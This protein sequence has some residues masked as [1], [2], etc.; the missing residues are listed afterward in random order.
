MTTSILGCLVGT[1]GAYDTHGR[2]FAYNPRDLR[3]VTFRLVKPPPWGVVIGALRNT[4]VRRRDSQAVASMPVLEPVRWSFSPMTISSMASR[5]PAA[6]STR[7]VES[8]IS[9]PIPSPLAIV[10]GTAFGRSP[11][12]DT[13]V[14][15]VDGIYVDV[16]G[17][18]VA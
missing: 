6:L 3:T 15:D 5:A 18:P 12:E 11:I 10:I 16:I 8:M 13:T 4:F 14:L 2:T 1:N 9:G 17:A 7:S